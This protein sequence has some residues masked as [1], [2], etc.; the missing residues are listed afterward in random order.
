MRTNDA[1]IDRRTPLVRRRLLPNLRA[2]VAVLSLVLLSVPL[3]GSPARAASDS[4]GT[5]FWLTFPGNLGTPELTL[6]ITGP[7]S[8]SGTRAASGRRRAIRR[9]RLTSRAGYG[10]AR[11]TARTGAR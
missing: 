2:F 3:M 9:S 8:T 10:A 4:I 1:A 5:D 6:F 7:T 11:R